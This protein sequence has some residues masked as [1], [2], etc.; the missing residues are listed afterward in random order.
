V[1]PAA[2][3]PTLAGEFTR[4]LAGVNMWALLLPYVVVRI[5]L[6]LSEWVV[7]SGTT[8]E[9]AWGRVL[10]AGPLMLALGF[11]VLFV[12]GQGLRGMLYAMKYKV[13]PLAPTGK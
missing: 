3:R 6:S 8:G 1:T 10:V 4:F 13:P 12:A 2:P 7:D 9:F 11:I 5:V